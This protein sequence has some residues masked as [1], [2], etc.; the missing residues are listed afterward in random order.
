MS[1]APET[2][3]VAEGTPAP[4]PRPSTKPVWTSPLQPATQSEQPSVVFGETKKLRRLVEEGV[5]HRMLA[6]QL[7][8]GNRSSL[9]PLMFGTACCFIE[10]ASAAASRF[11][12]ARFG[13]EVMRASPRQADL[14]I[15]PGTVTKKMIPEIVRLWHQMAEPKYCIA[16]GACAISGGPFKEGY[17]V[18]SGVDE[19]VPVDVYVPGC[20]PKPEALLWG[21]IK[22]QEKIAGHPLPELWS[23]DD[24]GAPVPLLGPDLIDERQVAEIRRR[25]AETPPPSV[26]TPYGKGKPPALVAAGQC[27]LEGAEDLLGALALPNVAE[28]ATDGKRT[29]AVGQLVAVAGA[30]QSAG[31]TYLSS[32]T[33]VDYADHLEVVYHFFRIPADGLDLA[34]G[35]AT[36]ER[37]L[38]LRAGVERENPVVAS[39]TP[40]YPGV[41]FQE[42]EIYDLFGVR[43]EAHP[44]LTRILLWD[45]FEGHPMRKDY[46]EPYFE[47][48]KP[49]DSRW[50]E[51]NFYWAEQ[52]T[53]YGRNVRYPTDFEAHPIEPG[54]DRP[55]KEHLAALTA[56]GK[57]DEQFVI[58]IGPQHPSTHGV[59]RMVAT[60]DG[61]TVTALT[62]VFGYLHRNHEKIGERNLYIQNMPFTDR[63]DYMGPMANNFG[64]ALAVEK[65]LKVAVPERAEYIRV[66]MAELTR[67]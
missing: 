32:A 49:L 23:A 22:L 9:W 14:M 13:S 27:V 45:E 62:P 3:A 37:G 60:V 7:N 63:L 18:V 11:D 55:M 38:A 25:A 51:G 19:F 31:W 24:R 17:H 35:Y 6:P 54:H 42:R 36:A 21:I 4:E 28:P 34:P 20:P 57:E 53:P 15:V 65:L 1:Q 26:D 46:V 67:I 33:G 48:A 5:L 8:W 64:Y 56:A 44:H 47:G 52:K 43:F 40:L 61:E 58:N 16:M 50:P 39:L 66:I 41:D 10:M 2:P 30:L 29:F 12:L 59:F